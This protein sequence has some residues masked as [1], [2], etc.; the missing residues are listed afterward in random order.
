[1][2]RR[3]AAVAL[4]C[5]GCGAQFHPETLVD[6]M[7]ILSVVAEAPEIHPGGQ[8][9]LT[10]LETDPSRPGGVTTLFWLGC[11]PDPVGFNRSTCADVS[12]LLHPSTFADYPPDLRLLGFGD[13]VSYG[14]PAG[15]FDAL[16]A[17]DPIL[18]NGTSGPVLL[19]AVAALVTPTTSI[20]DL[21][22]LFGQMER[23]EV[24]NV[25]ALTR[26]AISTRA[27]LNHNPRLS[28]VLVDGAEVP[29][30]ARVQVRPGGATTLHLEAPPEARESYELAL[31]GGTQ[32]RTEQLV[33]A[34]YSTGGRFSRAR[35][36]LDGGED[37]VFT[38]PGGSADDP[39]PARRFG[40]LWVVLRDDR[41]GESNAAFPFY[42]CD[43]SPA[44][45]LTSVTPPTGPGGQTVVTGTDLESVLDLLVGGRV[46]GRLRYDAARG[47]LVG[48]LPPLGAGSWPV[49]VR[50]KSCG[51]F[52]AGLSVVLP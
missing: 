11:D 9:T 26:V 41:G 16:D 42:V 44:P 25:L 46:V 48:D 37:T 10:A 51:D 21:R 20:P 1:V 47:V 12:A 5:A 22:V 15:L 3:A 43:D 6:S 39:V 33:A 31:P 19:V 13:T 18:V 17:G 35:V 29:A 32:A 34:W 27:T 28:R 30:G 40:N 2:V 36:D 52:D 50:S 23:G 8:T 45:R 14:A 38:A 7:R 49:R 24:A 4:L